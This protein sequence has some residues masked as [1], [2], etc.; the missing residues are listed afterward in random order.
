MARRRDALRHRRRPA[1]ASFLRRLQHVRP[2]DAPLRSAPVH[3]RQVDAQLS[4]HA[5]RH[6]RGAHLSR[7][8]ILPLDIAGLRQPLEQPSTGAFGRL[9]ALSAAAEAA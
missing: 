5:P 6:G 8:G 1:A 2:V 7:S 9:A 3:R 4:R